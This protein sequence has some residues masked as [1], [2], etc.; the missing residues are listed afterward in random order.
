V[1]VDSFLLTLNKS[2][3]NKRIINPMGVTTIKK[4]TPITTGETILPKSIPNFIQS[5]FN[6]VKILEFKI[7]KIKKI[8]DSIKAHNLKSSCD[9]RGHNDIAKKT[10]KNKNPKLLL[11]GILTESFFISPNL[12]LIETFYSR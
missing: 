3:P 5:L 6:G 1:E 8:R 10:M 4:T 11:D 2:L 12:T 9:I 7:P